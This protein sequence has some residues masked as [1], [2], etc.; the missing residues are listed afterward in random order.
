MYYSEW[1]MKIYTNIQEVN[2][3]LNAAGFCPKTMLKNKSENILGLPG[4]GW[5]WFGQATEHTWHHD[6][7]QKEFEMLAEGEKYWMW[8]IV[9]GQKRVFFL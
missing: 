7:K 4:T 2:F 8:S 9:A 1:I 6:L 3:F 5:N